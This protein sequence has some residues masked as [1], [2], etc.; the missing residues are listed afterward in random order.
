MSW[1]AGR[2]L[3]QANGGDYIIP[4][5]LAEQASYNAIFGSLAG[6]NG[7][8]GLY[9]NTSSPSYN[10][11]SQAAEA[12]TGWEW[13]DGTPLDYDAATDTWSGYQS[14]GSGEP[15]DYFFTGSENWAQ[16]W[17]QNNPGEF[18]NK[19]GAIR[20]NLAVIPETATNWPV[21]A[22]SNIPDN[23]L[24]VGPTTIKSAQYVNCFTHPNGTDLEPFQ[25][26]FGEMYG[27]AKNFQ[28]GTDYRT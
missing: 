21:D 24:Y 23:G 6:S 2:A 12:K 8:I 4:K 10:S 25:T 13:I 17:S 19:P 11:S 9:Q 1:D 3:C 27:A 16:F 20:Y 18:I 15:N 14:W 5:T 26:Y 28:L 7:W 22:T